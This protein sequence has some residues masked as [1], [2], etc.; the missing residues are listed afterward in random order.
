LARYQVILAYDGTGFEGFQRQPAKRSG[1]TVQGEVEAGLHKLGWTG[2]KILAAGRTDSGVHA[3]GQVIA[4]DL[5]WEHAPETLRNALNANLP[6]DISARKVCLASPAFHPRYDA[7]ARCY[8]YHLF[9]DPQRQPL[10]ERY[11]WRVWPP[12]ELERMQASARHLIGTHDF[13]SFGSP[14]RSQ[15]NTIRSVLQ[16]HWEA[17]EA[18]FMFE[19]RANAF[20][21][22]MVRRLVNLQVTIGQGRLEVE[23]VKQY[24]E[25]SQPGLAQ[26]MA[27][28]QGLFLA[29]VLYPQGSG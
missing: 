13:A 23:T 19:I 6:Q 25:A 8:R 9:C 7:L 11:A 2:Q 14:P 26:G 10:R 12:V 1:R 17:Q 16:A 3:S 15:G 21:Y 22:H 18:G 29:E 4:F 27:P 28:P 20:L 5:E 24:L